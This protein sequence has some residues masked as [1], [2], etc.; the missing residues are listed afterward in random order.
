MRKRARSNWQRNCG[1]KRGLFEMSRR[2]QLNSS[3]NSAI[4]TALVVIGTSAAAQIDF[5]AAEKSL[6]KSI[7]G[8]AFEMLSGTSSDRYEYS[9][10]ALEQCSLKWI[11]QR[12][13]FDS[14]HRTLREVVLTTVPL[15]VINDKS[16]RADRLKNG[17]YVV[18]LQTK[19]LES[20]IMT[21]VRRQWGDQPETQTTGVSSSSGWYFKDRA[22]AETVSKTIAWLVRACRSN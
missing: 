4:L 8:A 15:A 14:G 6:K 5:E 16:L 10:V 19:G 2:K 7:N 9:E 12:D 21:R 11:E 20:Q 13:T 22:T 18:A 17:G 3:I 1:M